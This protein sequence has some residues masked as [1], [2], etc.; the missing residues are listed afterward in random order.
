M[1]LLAAGVYDTWI[2]RSLARL[3]ELKPARYARTELSSGFLGSPERYEYA[4]PVP[5]PAVPDA[6][7]TIASNGGADASLQ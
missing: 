5:P 6:P 1:E 2:D 4:R 3:A 7:A